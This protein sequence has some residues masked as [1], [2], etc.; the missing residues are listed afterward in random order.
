[1]I[2]CARSSSIGILVV[3]VQD[4]SMIIIMMMVQ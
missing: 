1:M 2:T 3:V 4:I